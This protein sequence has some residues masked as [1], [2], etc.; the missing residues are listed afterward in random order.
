MKP[1]IR[2]VMHIDGTFVIM[3][4]QRGYRWRPQEVKLLLDDCYAHRNGSYC[5]QPVVVRMI[6]EKEYEL[7]DGQQRMT[8]LFLLRSRLARITQSSPDF[9]IEYRVREGSRDFLERLGS[10]DPF[11]EEA[12]TKMKEESERNIDFYFMF[13]A[14]EA[15]EDWLEKKTRDLNEKNTGRICWFLENGLSGNGSGG[16]TGIIWYETEENDTSGL[17]KRLN[18][19]KIP[20]T[21]SELIKALLLQEE[22]G[23]DE[24]DKARIARE[25]DEMSHRLNDDGLWYFITNRDPAGY[26]TR[27]D[28]LFELFLET[29]VHGDIDRYALFFRFSEFMHSRDCDMARIWEEFRLFYFEIL[30]WYENDELYNKIGYLV[31]SDVSGNSILK[32]RKLVIGRRKSEVI[33]I[34]DDMIRERIA[35]KKPYSELDYHIKA[36]H[37]LMERILLLFNIMSLMPFDADKGKYTHIVRFDFRRYKAEKWTLEHIHAQN[38]EILTSRK[39][40]MAWLEYHRKALEELE[41]I[42]SVDDASRKDLIVRISTMLG[43]KDLSLEDFRKVSEDVF[44]VLSPNDRTYYI[45]QLGN[46]ALLDLRN[47]AAIS[48]SVFDVKRQILRLKEQ[49]GEYIPHCTRL[50]F[51]KYYTSSADP[52]P[53]FWSE[54]DRRA[55]LDEIDRV[56]DP[57]LREER[58]N[59]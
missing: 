19:G 17:F 25:W 43:S 27:I 32:L 33:A 59:G 2:N 21:D 55:Y 29:E 1:E 52:N 45:D 30:N 7:I 16:G 48:N 47:N 14:Y 44:K 49:K 57:Y 41:G 23:S 5:L 38:A 40:Q 13:Q 9:R 56:L 4:Y 20:L 46:M 50:A 31:A 39:D 11:N 8:T 58:I 22:A 35:A 18:I 34:I 6:G 28:R 26:P 51:L 24:R 10:L 42:G 15:I 54:Y 37:D 12:R 3:P 36:D 53:H